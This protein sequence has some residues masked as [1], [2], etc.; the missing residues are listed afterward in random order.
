MA[1][2]LNGTTG[3]SAVQPGAVKSGDL[4]AGSVIQVVQENSTTQTST[5]STSFVS[6]NLSAS[7]TPISSNSKILIFYSTSSLSS[8]GRI[9]V[10][11]FRGGVSSGVNISPSTNEFEMQHSQV[12]EAAAISFSILDSPSTTS[13]ITYEVAFA[14][15]D[16][17]TMFVSHTS[18]PSV[19]TLMEIAG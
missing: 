14:A 11:V 19:L 16:S 1:L 15:R 3:V 6:A 13:A 2:E 18:S 12:T 7:I 17:G 5:T 8:N 4:P 10:T 9:K